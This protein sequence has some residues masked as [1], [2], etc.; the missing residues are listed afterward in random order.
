MLNV[1]IEEHSHASVSSYPR[2]RKEFATTLAI[3]LCI[4]FSAGIILSLI[5]YF[6]DFDIYLAYRSTLTQ[7]EPL[8]VSTCEESSKLLHSEYEPIEEHPRKI[9]HASSIEKT[10]KQDMATNAIIDYDSL[11]TEY[12]LYHLAKEVREK[13]FDVGLALRF[14]MADLADYKES[15]PDNLHLRLLKLLVDWMK[16]IESPTVKV[17]LSACREA[18]VGGVAKRVLASSWDKPTAN[19]KIY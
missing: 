12:Q 8:K 13:W 6:Y 16:Q 2:Q 4:M 9:D 7:E 17:L 15:M 5:I 3:L 11:V 10:R 18:G 1:V 14:T 19:S